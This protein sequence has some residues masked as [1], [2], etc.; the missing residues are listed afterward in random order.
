MYFRGMQMYLITEEIFVF[1][2]T[3]HHG[4]HRDTWIFVT[5]YS[6]YYLIS[7]LLI[8]QPNRD[9]ETNISPAFSN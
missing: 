9:L 6:K 3:I 2:G 7:P 1:F 4:A 5:R 8:N